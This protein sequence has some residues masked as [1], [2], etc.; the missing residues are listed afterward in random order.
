MRFGAS[1][2]KSLTAS[3]PPPASKYWY[4][5][6]RGEDQLVVEASWAGGKVEEQERGGGQTFVLSHMLSTRRAMALSSTTRTLRGLG[7]AVEAS[8]SSLRLTEEERGFAAVEGGGGGGGGG[9]ELTGWLKDGD[10]EGE[11]SCV[12]L[13]ESSSDTLRRRK[14]GRLAE[15][16]EEEGDEMISMGMVTVASVPLPISLWYSMRP[17]MRPTSWAERETPRPA[18]QLK[19]FSCAKGVNLLGRRSAMAMTEEGKKRTNRLSRMNSAVIPRPLSMTEK[20][21]VRVESSVEGTSLIRS[22][23]WPFEV[24]CGGRRGQ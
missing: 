7:E 23:I 10:G 13:P 15:W 11:G 24:N 21:K 16:V 12:I 1:C 19:E 3:A 14:D 4:F 22:V 6:S 18:P 20:R 2:L 17:P 8:S 9:V 5:Y